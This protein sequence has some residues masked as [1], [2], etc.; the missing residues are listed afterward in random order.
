MQT[1]TQAQRIIQIEVIF[2]DWD[3]LHTQDRFEDCERKEMLYLER[4]NT[5]NKRA[6]FRG[7]GGMVNGTLV[8]PKG[9]P[10]KQSDSDCYFK[11]E[12]GAYHMYLKVERDA[13]H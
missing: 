13:R 5:Q 11:D 9:N 12:L 2:E 6:W 10:I 1:A 4:L 3:E 7:R 8:T